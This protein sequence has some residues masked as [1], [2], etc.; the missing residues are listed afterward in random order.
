VDS[1]GMGQS[2]EKFKIRDLTIL[3]LRPPRYQSLGN[4]SGE[5]TC[6]VGAPMSPLAFIAVS[7]VEGL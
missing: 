1:G 6:N 4:L 7:T 3:I 5:E 2:L